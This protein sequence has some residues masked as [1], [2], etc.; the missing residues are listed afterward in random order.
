GTASRTPACATPRSPRRSVPVRCRRCTRRRAR[1]RTSNRSNRAS[2]RPEV[3]RPAPAANC[4]YSLDPAAGKCGRYVVIENARSQKPRG[5]SVS[6]RDHAATR[7]LPDVLAAALLGRRFRLLVGSATLGALR[8][9][10]STCGLAFGGALGL[11]VGLV[12][13]GARPED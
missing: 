12:A 1:F 2:W 7:S 3:A 13:C 8:R 5:R 11:E 9:S 10:R 4:S 6:S